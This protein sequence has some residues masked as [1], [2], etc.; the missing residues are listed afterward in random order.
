VL[1]LCFVFCSNHLL[2][3]FGLVL[4]SFTGTSHLVTGGKKTASYV[5]SLFD[6]WVVKLDP[7]STRIDCVFFDGASNVQK[8]GRLLEAKYPRISVQSCA[9]HSVSLFFSDI[10]TKIWQFRLMLVNYRRVYRL[11]GSGSMHSPYALFLQQSKNFNGG[12]KVGLIKAADTRMAGHAYAQC[13][14][15]RLR[16][17]LMATITSAAYIDLKLKG[18]AKK[19]EE[20]LSN[21]DMW[22][23]A[24]T[25]Q[26]CLFPMIRV[27]RLCDQ[28]AC[29][30]MSKIV[31]YV[32]RT[33][34]ALERSM[35]SLKNLALFRDYGEHDAEDDDEDLDDD[36]ETNDEEADVQHDGSDHDD[37]DS[38]TTDEEEEDVN[39]HLGE[40]IVSFW[41]KRRTRLITPLSL[42]GWFCSPHDAIR[43]DVREHEKGVDRL[44]IEKVIEKIYY[45]STPDAL[46]QIIQTFWHEFDDFQTRH[47]RSYS[48][49]WIW[50]TDEIKNGED[51]VWH[52][53]YSVPFTTVF[54]R[55]ACRVC[56]KPLGCGL[57]ERNWGALKHLKTGKRSH[58][59]G[60]K[61]QKQAT[62]FGAAC[63]DRARA[64]EAAEDFNGII[65]ETRWTDADITTQMGLEN[66]DVVPG[67]LPI[68]EPPEQPTE[69]PIAMGPRRVFKAWLEDWE[70]K[71]MHNNDVVV[72]AK[73][74]QKYGGLRWID[75]EC[76][77]ELECEGVRFY[78]GRVKAGWALVA[79]RLHDGKID[80]W[81]CD[82]A[83]DEI[84]EF[85]QPREMNVE[86]VIDEAKR[87]FNVQQFK[88][89][90]DRKRNEAARKR[91]AKRRKT[92]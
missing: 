2:V 20:Y 74:L 71:A 42:A 61:A 8:A 28:S 87:A 52:K 81:T 22:I 5:A 90:A 36:D 58:L 11:F 37:S 47:G 79:K 73:F 19:V 7:S 49:P 41:K 83:V 65:L 43:Q 50:D 85:E 51:H 26:R 40:Q 1:P 72:E 92:T 80:T 69:Q 48:R 76:G 10:N 23:A 31:F 45:P 66:W 82:L 89:I 3:A 4:L 53:I 68:L 55:V 18:L 91:M 84:A 33:D 88:D 56:S 39:N 17:P 6:P 62:I 21:P 57:A 34:E 59:S 9:A 54:G 16:E 15:L 60:D 78:G 32:H 27:L 67:N 35:E 44:E 75:L 38:E 63:I 46:G 86:V 24:Y 29:G 14:M 13:R 64:M 25:I 70:F 12:R 30:G 77:Y